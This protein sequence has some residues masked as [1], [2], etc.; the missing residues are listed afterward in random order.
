MAIWVKNQTL[1]KQ[2]IVQA[3]KKENKLFDQQEQ[4]KQDIE[5]EA[6]KEVMLE[7]NP[8]VSTVS[9]SAPRG[10]SGPL[11]LPLKRM[12]HRLVSH[13]LTT[14]PAIPNSH[15]EDPPRPVILMTV[16]PLSSSCRDP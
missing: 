13:Q 8:E 16:R 10:G 12:S 3:M 14:H 15:R 6:E 5:Q 1:V 7:N 2:W 11:L 4:A 9:P